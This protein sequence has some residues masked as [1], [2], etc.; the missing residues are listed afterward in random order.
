MG[1]NFE[2][3]QSN[4]LSIFHALQ[5]HR[6]L[7]RKE[8][9]AITKLSWGS[10]SAICNDLL[11]KGIIIAEKEAATTGRPPERLTIS[12]KKKLS[13]GI[14]INSVG[15]S[16]NVVNLAGVSV[17]SE[18]FILE[19]RKK[20]DL[21]DVLKKKTGAILENFND[22]ISIN[23]SMQGALDRKS[24]ISLRSNFFE[25]WNNVPLVEFFEK[26]FLIQTFLYHDPE[27][28]LTFHLANDARL[29]NKH[30]GIVIRIDDGIGMAQITNDI[31]YES[32]GN[33]ACELGHITVVPEG[34][35]CPCG[36]K[37]CL[38]VYSSIRGMKNLYNIPE[39]YSSEKFITDM[40]QQ[41]EKS[42]AVLQQASMYLGLSI[43]NLFTLYNP[44]FIILDGNAIAKLPIFFEEIKKYIHLFYNGNFNLLQANYH[45]DAAAIGAAMITIDKLLEK[46]IFQTSE[47]Y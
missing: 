14:D 32:D 20:L 44:D 13:L 22:I 17:Y 29:R 2:L 11:E 27:C 18:F 45:K 35:P 41:D 28:L 8:L 6:Y 15:L 37:G 34:L 39:N 42:K 25:D 40:C 47:N 16:F 1:R 9:E 21:L 43:A 26:N 5:K 3:K 19:S 7:S 10:V 46:I 38:E 31:L 4:I 12:T 30:N 33:P 24:G 36:K 23:L